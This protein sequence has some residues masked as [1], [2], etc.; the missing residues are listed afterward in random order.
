MKR[1]TVWCIKEVFGSLK[2]RWNC[3]KIWNFLKLFRVQV[4]G[5]TLWNLCKLVEVTGRNFCPLPFWSLSHP[6][7]FRGNSLNSAGKREEEGSSTPLNSSRPPSPQSRPPLPVNSWEGGDR[8][9]RR[10]R[11]GWVGLDGGKQPHLAL[12]LL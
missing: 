1:P 10:R 11:R 6:T 12:L 7:F 2:V 9:T 4:F 8:D 5:W 3:R